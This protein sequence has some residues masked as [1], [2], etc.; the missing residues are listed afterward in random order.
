MRAVSN[1]ERGALAARPLAKG[2]PWRE[3]LAAL[4]LALAL[5]GGWL[6]LPRE[7]TY[8]SGVIGAGSGRATNKVGFYVVEADPGGSPYRW[9][10]GYA[11]VQMPW[12]YRAAPAYLAEVRLR[13]ENPAGPQPLTFL[14][15]ERPLATVTPTEGF[16]VYRLALPPPEASGPEL[17]LGLQTTP[18]RPAENPRPLGVIVTDAVLRAAPFTDWPAL[19]ALALGPLALLA[20]LR[21]RR[22]GAGDGLLVAGAVGLALLLLGWRAEPAPLRVEWMAGLALAG[23]AGAA[24]LA[25][26]TAARLGLGLLC[27]LAAFSGAIWPSWL[28]D[29]AFISFRYAQN[30]V[31]G[32]GLV[33]NLGERVEGYTNFLWTMLA[34]LALW[35][36]ADIVLASYAA[37]VLLALALILATYAVARGLLGPAWALVAALLVATSQSLLVYTA[38]GGGLETGLFA[39]LALAG[40]GAYLRASA[41]ERDRTGPAGG[42]WTLAAGLLLGLATLTRPE[43]AMIFGLTALRCI[44]YDVRLTIGDLRHIHDLS[45]D[46]GRKVFRLATL[47]APYAAVVLPFFA[48]RYDYY[49]DLLP[50]T[51]YAKT[52][53]GPLVWLR[54]L[55]YLGGFALDFGGPLL[56]LAPAALGY[57]RPGTGEAPAIR[58]Q[59]PQRIAVLLAS[60]P[61]Y[62]LLL[63]LV[64][65]AYVVYVG[66]DHFPGHR[67]LVPLVP[68]L[69]LLMAA[70]LARLWAGL[71]ARGAAARLAPALLAAL[72]VTYGGYALTRSERYDAVLAGNDE[73]LWL[74][75]EIGWWLRDNAAP[76]ESAAAMGAGAIAYYSD[77]TIVDLLGLTERH[78][79]RV[80]VPEAGSGAA[81]HEKRDP[82][83]VLDV[84]RPTYIPRIWDDYFGGPRALRREYELISVST[85][86]GRAIELW[87]RLP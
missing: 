62:L 26:E 64:Y 41:A 4:L 19:L 16:R 74:W 59:G 40:T 8:D 34:A 58:G 52:G 35:L 11:F 20:W 86:Y 68:W 36:G 50:N 70:G 83:Y 5:G 54:G 38:R 48:W 14:A 37:G 39:L 21:L 45:S 28:S 78:I 84:R 67:F 22:A 79:A 75:A 33:Y 13:A 18:F 10:S 71:R 63:C 27:A 15:N 56:L 49:G 76:D 65:A 44:V 24:A 53:G 46:A 1:I 23:A 47:A 51:F 80:S 73:S 25:R 69:A 32:N 60:W 31:A 81:G 87:R 57:A 55:A 82:A 43:G 42:C 7:R 9:T 72:L 77:R 85:R 61:A 6:A 3:W 2:A 29:D 17:R 66:G 30:L 12:A